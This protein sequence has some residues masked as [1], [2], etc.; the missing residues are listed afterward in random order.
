[1]GHLRHGYTNS[2]IGD[3]FFVVKC[4]EGPD[5]EARLRTERT[6]LRRYKGRLPVPALVRESD[7]SLTTRFVTG[8]H[9]QDLIE[10]GR[11]AEVLA[12]CGRLLQRIQSMPA[13]S[14]KVLVHGDFGPQNLLMEPET[15][16]DWEW[17]H[18]GDPV[19]DL[20]WCEWIVRTHHPEHVAALPY[21]FEAYG[22]E[23]PAWAE[24]QAA[25]LARCEELADFCGRWEPGGP[26]EKEWRARIEATA[27]WAA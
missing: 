3:G 22:G 8:E 17:A 1:M 26:G 21:L 14:G 7:S 27:S 25:M 23:V 20:A 6:M 19:E 12:A 9:G 10:D 11:A 24:R 15:L 18:L 5:A 2:T 4:Y 13:R 16:L